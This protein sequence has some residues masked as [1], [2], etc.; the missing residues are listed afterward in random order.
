MKHYALLPLLLLL[1]LSSACVTDDDVPVPADRLT[2]VELILRQPPATQLV[3]RW[4]DNDG[5]GG[6][7]PA[8]DIVTLPPNSSYTYILRLLDQTDVL[9]QV[10][11]TS[12]IRFAGTDYLVCALAAGTAVDSLTT[13]DED[14][15]GAPLGLEGTLRTGSAGT[16]QMRILVLRDPDKSLPSRCGTGEAILDA[17]LLIDVQ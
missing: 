7:M 13:T 8:A 6:N 12:E 1:L 5:P 11:R 4:I 10:D 2:S 16:A 14:A 3:F 15:N 17:S 9:A